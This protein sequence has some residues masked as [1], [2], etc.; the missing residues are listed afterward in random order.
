MQRFVAAGVWVWSTA[1]AVGFLA[2]VAFLAATSAVGLL[3]W[4]ALKRYVD[5]QLDSRLSKKR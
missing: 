1:N 4:Q 5:R 2:M 3:I